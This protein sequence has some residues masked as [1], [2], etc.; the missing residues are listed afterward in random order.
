VSNKDIIIAYLPKKGNIP[1]TK[2]DFIAVYRKK[3]RSVRHEY[4]TLA[5]K[6]SDMGTFMFTFTSSSKHGTYVKLRL[7]NEIKSYV[8]YLIANSK[9]D[10]YFF[11]NIELGHSLTNPHLH[12]QVW[13]DDKKAVEKI[14]ERVIDKFSLDKKRCKLSEPQQT[15]MNYYNYVIKDYSEALSNEQLLKLEQTKKKYRKQL[16]LKFRFYSRSKSKYQSKLYKIMYRSYGILRAKADEFLDW[17]L[18]LFFNKQRTFKQTISSFISIKNKWIDCLENSFFTFQFDFFFGDVIS[19]YGF[20][21]ANAPP[22]LLLFLY[23]NSKGDV[24]FLSLFT[25]FSIMLTAYRLLWLV[26]VGLFLDLKIIC[27]LFGFVF[28]IYARCLYP[29][30]FLL[31]FGRNSGEFS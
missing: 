16:G 2:S 28:S 27:F 15:S 8:T 18:P 13:S 5:S 24:L 31:V 10:I 4:L 25:L 14:Y 26:W 7:I 29:P 21:P 9:A 12:T 1:L 30:V 23:F 22:I 6:Y 19:F 3:N 11:S 17:F 20:A